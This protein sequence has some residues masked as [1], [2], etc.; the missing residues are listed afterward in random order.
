MPDAL[1]MIGLGLLGS[2]LAARFRRAGLEVVG[3]DVRPAAREALAAQ[4]ARAAPS[5]VEVVAACPR[6]VLCLPDSSVVAAVI[7]EVKG[8]LREG[9]LLI[10]TT[11]GAPE[12]AEALARD[13]A[14]RGVGYLDATVLGSSEQARAGEVIVMAGG[15]RELAERAAELF[16]CFAA[17]W[18]HA[19][20]NGAGARMK[21][22]VNLVLGLNRAALAEGLALARSCGLELPATLD[23]LRAGAAYSRVMDT[24]GEKMLRRD[25]APQAR[26]A[27]HLKD[28]RLILALAGPPGLELPLTLAH[29]ELLERVVAMGGGEDDNSAVIRAYDAPRSE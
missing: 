29:R 22:V 26:L 14:G 10:D 3:F 1:G 19:G 12:D 21:L 13:L 24:K 11:T 16:A 18:F 4:G 28:V 7:G 8:A 20:P 27:Q 25:F 9:Q 2:A 15:P 5:A 6:V 23:V 17:R